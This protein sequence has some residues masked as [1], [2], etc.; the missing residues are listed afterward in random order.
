MLKGREQLVLLGTEVKLGKQLQSHTQGIQG[1]STRQRMASK[2]TE[3][4]KNDR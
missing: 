3:C 1:K 4:L 2:Q